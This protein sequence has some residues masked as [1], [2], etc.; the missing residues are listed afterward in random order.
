MYL[1]V[2][3]LED[4]V[5]ALDANEKSK[6]LI[7]GV[8]K[9]NA[10]FSVTDY[11]QKK[12]STISCI[13]NLG[14]VGSQKF[15]QGTLVEIVRCYQR[16][17]DFFSR[18]VELRK[19][20]QLPSAICGTGD[21]VEPFGESDP[22]DVVDMELFALAQFCQNRSI[23]YVSIKYVTD[24]NEGN[25]MPVWKKQLPLAS[26]ALSQFWMANKQQIL[27]ELCKK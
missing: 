20:T 4:E 17:T 3:A 8:G 6:L 15:V 26:G 7:S 22:W 11:L 27:S 2:A 13:V 12:T 9:L 18:P 1:I 14:T 23:P 10:L 5:G 25:V 16:D 19:M 21:R 24:R